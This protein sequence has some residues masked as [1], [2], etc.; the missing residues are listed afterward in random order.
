MRHGIK[1]T[2]LFTPKLNG[3]WQDDISFESFWQKI[4]VAEGEMCLLYLAKDKKPSWVSTLSGHT[5][6]PGANCKYLVFIFG[7][8]T[9]ST[10]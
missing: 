8:E 2:F 3:V 9:I 1:V 6:K 10:N 5:L 7:V 4:G